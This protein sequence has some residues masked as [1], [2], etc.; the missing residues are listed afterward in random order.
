MRAACFARRLHLTGTAT[1]VYERP[2]DSGA[3]DADN[4][5]DRDISTTTR[6]LTNVARGHRH[7]ADRL[8]RALTP[9]WW[10]SSPV[11]LAL[12]R[13]LL[14]WSAAAWLTEQPDF[15]RSALSTALPPKDVF[16][17]RSVLTA[18]RWPET[19]TVL[20][21]KLLQLLLSFALAGLMAPLSLLGAG[22]L[23]MHYRAAQKVLTL[24]DG[25]HADLLGPVMLL[26]AGSP[27]A[28]VLS[29][30]ELLARLWMGPVKRSGA[31]KGGWRGALRRYA[32]DLQAATRARSRAY[33]A[34]LIFAG[35][36]I[37]LLYLSCGL[38]KARWGPTFVLS[39][40]N[41]GF[42]RSNIAGMWLRRWGEARVPSVWAALTAPVQAPFRTYLLP[43]LRLDLLPGFLEFGAVF[44]AVWELL[45]WYLML[46]APAARAACL[47]CMM[48]FHLMAAQ[49]MAIDYYQ[50]AAVQLA[51]FLPWGKILDAVLLRRWLGPSAGPGET[52]PHA[53]APAPKA[54]TT[55]A[56]GIRDRP[57]VWT[58]IALGALIVMGQGL[59]FFPSTHVLP[60]DAR[61][62]PFNHGP[63]F[64]SHGKAKPYG[65]DGNQWAWKGVNAEAISR[66]MVLHLPGGDSVRYPVWQAICIIGG[67]KETCAA[68]VAGRMEVSYW[69][70]V[71]EDKHYKDQLMLQFLYDP[72]R[73]IAPPSDT[74]Y[75]TLGGL[76]LREPA[77]LPDGGRGGNATAVS[78]ESSELVPMRMEQTLADIMAQAK[79]TCRGGLVT[80]PGVNASSV[81]A[82]RSCTPPAPKKAKPV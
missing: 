27:C 63:S 35:L 24:G 72:W 65:S 54:Q 49:T 8:R 18:W 41:S 15:V 12:V 48:T 75:A 26:L 22:A 51:L 37:G 74:Q 32:A 3:V 29:V 53:T 36:Y 5:A 10:T 30:D 82:E 78:F 13:V 68:H 56:P 17:G 64:T 25:L 42:V 11:D 19:F 43:V 79:M 28:D 50:F 60:Y 47:L 69:C 1:A 70:C 44:T 33:S 57:L 7:W 34:P 9:R 58:T 40:A 61:C 77:L 55:T 31:G 23:M 71:N 38:V 20:E 81:Q 52:L 45:Y 66:H 14:V 4:D 80:P 16:M 46:C 6:G 21:L 59:E 76:A 67:Y 39:W 2:K 73:L 62:F